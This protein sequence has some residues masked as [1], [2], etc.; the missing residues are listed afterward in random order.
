VSMLFEERSSDSPYVAT[1]MRGQTVSDGSTIRPAEN[2]W[3]MVFVRHTS[4][5]QPLIVG[6]WTRA[7]IASWKAGGE[8]LWIKFKLGVFMPH[9]P[10]RNF[11]DQEMMA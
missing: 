10:T 8:V 5:L 2:G 3:H 9:L 11:L 6:P 1:I 4:G 7:G